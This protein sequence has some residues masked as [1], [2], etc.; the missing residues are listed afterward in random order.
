[1]IGFQRGEIVARCTVSDWS[2]LKNTLAEGINL[3]DVIHEG[4]GCGGTRCC[5]LITTV[6]SC[7]CIP[8]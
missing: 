6:L 4:D 8:I 2:K 5:Q 7:A 3:A 1:M